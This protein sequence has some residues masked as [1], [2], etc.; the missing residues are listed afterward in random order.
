MPAAAIIFCFASREPIE[1]GVRCDADAGL[2][3]F[4]AGA[5]EKYLGGNAAR[6][7]NLRRTPH[8]ANRTARRR[9]FK[10]FVGEFKR[11]GEHDFIQQF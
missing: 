3:V 4:G 8:L 5:F 10:Q 9:A 7:P 2:A 6:A 1:S 11:G